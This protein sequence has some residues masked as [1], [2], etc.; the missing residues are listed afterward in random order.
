MTFPDGANQPGSRKRRAL[1]DPRR[2]DQNRRAYES[3]IIRQQTMEPWSRGHYDLAGEAEAKMFHVKH[4]RLLFAFEN[5]RV[6]IDK[7]RTR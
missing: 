4:F 5:S 6:T 1:D 3:S 7:G 2:K